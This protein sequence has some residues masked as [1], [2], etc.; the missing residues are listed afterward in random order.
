MSN[1]IY[2]PYFYI[3]EDTRNGVYYAGSK[4][5][6]DANPTTFMIE[7]GYETSSE[8]IKELIREYGLDNFIIRK[9][10]TFQSGDEA[11]NYETRFL[12]KVDARNHPRFYNGHNN[13][14]LNYL[15][16]KES[17]MQIFGVDHNMKIP[18]K[19]ESRKKAIIKKWGSY[20]N[21]MIETGAIEKS[22]STCETRYG[23][24]YAFLTEEAI[25]KKEKVCIEK[26]GV[27]NAFQSQKLQRE[28]KEKG[29]LTFAKNY[30]ENQKP[31]IQALLE[32]NIDFCSFGWVTPAAEI[33]GITPQKVGRWMKRNMPEFY[34]EK[35]FK[36]KSRV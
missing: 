2:Q 26:Y 34:E 14:G 6:K 36:R 30:D 35:C 11:Y 33:I 28:M 24:R 10:R 32:S 21:M 8:T 17:M 19:Q 5:G 18:Q 23:T 4:Y 7:D 1:G 27:K 16:S 25:A 20:S 9:I 29:R 13:D 15:K 12:Q 3:I 31:I 22:F